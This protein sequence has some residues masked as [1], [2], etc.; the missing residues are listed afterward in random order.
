MLNNHTQSK[1]IGMTCGGWGSPWGPFPGWNDL[2][3]ARYSA[4]AMNPPSSAGWQTS[5]G[6][7][8]TSSGPVPTPVRTVFT[9][10]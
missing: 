8:Y 5:Q 6:Q 2:D 3:D 9:V 7:L 4:E 10:S 1:A